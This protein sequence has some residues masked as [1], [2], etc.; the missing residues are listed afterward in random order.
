MMGINSPVTL[1]SIVI[2]LAVIMDIGTNR[3]KEST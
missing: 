2:I 3:L 1:L